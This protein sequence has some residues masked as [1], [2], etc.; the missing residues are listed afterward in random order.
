MP[1]GKPGGGKLYQINLGFSFL[2]PATD[3]GKGISI[4]FIAG[5]GNGGRNGGAGSWR[6]AMSALCC[7]RATRKSASGMTLYEIRG[8]LDAAAACV[9]AVPNSASLRAFHSCFAFSGTP[10]I[11]NISTSK[12]SRPGKVLVKLRGQLG[13]RHFKEDLRLRLAFVNLRAVHH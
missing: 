8:L 7:A 4:P 5:G 10:S 2:T 6:L 1:I 3:L 9:T 13:E 12:P 11:P